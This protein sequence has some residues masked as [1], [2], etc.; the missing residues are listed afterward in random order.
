M[1]GKMN[2]IHSI[3]AEMCTG[4]GACEVACPIDCITMKTDAE[5][6]LTPVIDGERC[7]SCGR[8]LR[9]CPIGSECQLAEPRRVVAFRS[10]DSA[11]RDSSSGGAAYALGKLEITQ[12]GAVV[13]C[14]FDEE[15]VARHVVAKEDKTLR[16]MQGS[17]YVQSDARM[18]YRAIGALLDVG[19][20]VL[21]VGTPCQVCAV[22]SLYPDENL[23]I[24]CDLVCHGVPSPEYWR[25]ELEW[26]NE[27]KRLLNR[28]AVM[29]RSSN[30]RYRTKYELYCKCE[31]RGRLSQDRDPYFTTFVDNVS[32][33]ESCYR[34][35]FAR[36]ERTGDITIGDCASYNEYLD[37][38]PYEPISTLMANTETGARLLSKLISSSE[39]DYIEIDYELEKTLNKNLHAPSIRPAQRDAVYHDLMHMSYDDFARKYR[40]PRNVSWVGRKALEI[41][42]PNRFR[43]LVKKIVRAMH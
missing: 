11:T 21:F 7:V 41:L 23:L 24:T 3:T 18:G 4:C 6:F 12:G 33:R 8:C 40:K 38:H 30:H 10:L 28:S 19:C 17:K 39:A 20:E 1:H 32:L 37:F 36:G 43:V 34:C 25:R 9:V 27:K 13:G 26:N 16:A 22:R 2:N 35:L 15:G 42:F 31:S 29:F 14:S 5:G